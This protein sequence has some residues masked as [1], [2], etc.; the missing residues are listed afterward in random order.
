MDNT[1]A[2]GGHRIEQDEYQ[3]PAETYSLQ[4]NSNTAL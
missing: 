3:S 2:I 1:F 4:H